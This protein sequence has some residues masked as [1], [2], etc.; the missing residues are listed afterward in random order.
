MLPVPELA[1]RSGM[2]APT[3]GVTT[4][5]LASKNL[6][7]V[8]AIIGKSNNRRIGTLVL[9]IRPE[10]FSTIFNDVALGSGTEIC[11]IDASNKKLIVRADGTSTNPEGTIVPGLIAKIASNAPHEP[12]GFVDFEG[13]RGE[14]YLAAYT[15]GIPGTTWFVVSTVPEKS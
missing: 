9:V 13:K 4:T 6:G 1:P 14:R 11:V 10:H 12:G 8:R 3:G 7:M 15:S 5:A 2:A